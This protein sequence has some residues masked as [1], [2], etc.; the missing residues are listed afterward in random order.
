MS[1]NQTFD[2]EEVATVV[3][4][5]VLGEISIEEGADRLDV[6]PA[7]LRRILEDAGVIPRQGP[8]TLQDVYDEISVA[9][10]IE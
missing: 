9:R 2:D 8:A 6:D 5:H 10:R 7:Y 3:G 4:L 1:P